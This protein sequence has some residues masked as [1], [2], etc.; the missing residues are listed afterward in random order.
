MQSRAIPDSSITASSYYHVVFPPEDGRLHKES[1][2]NPGMWSPADARR[3]GEWLQVDLGKVTM[4]TAIATQGKPHGS[5][6]WVKSYSLKYSNNGSFFHDYFGGK[7]LDGNRDRNTVVKHEL[8]PPINAR[9]VRVYP[10]TWY[11][12]ASLRMELYG[13]KSGKTLY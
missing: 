11:K 1:S 7:V 10:K 8:V 5:D 13:C 3:H 2:I 4:V 6:E 9:Y 12:E